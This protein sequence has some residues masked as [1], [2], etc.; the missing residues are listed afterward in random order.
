[1]IGDSREGSIRK[2]RVNQDTEANKNIPKGEHQKVKR[3]KKKS[4]SEI[5]QK[6]KKGV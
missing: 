1:M 4:P 6:K 2:K 5:R 3:E